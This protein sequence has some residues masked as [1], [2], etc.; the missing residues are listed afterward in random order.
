ML[1]PVKVYKLFYF[2]SDLVFT[3]VFPHLT[4]ALFCPEWVNPLGSAV[5]FIF[6]ALMRYVVVSSTA[7]GIKFSNLIFLFRLL[8]GEEI[9]NIPVYIRWPFFDEE[10]DMNLFPFK[11]FCML[12][13]LLGSVHT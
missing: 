11:S 6:G 7:N 10:N 8:S 2:C 13:T 5:A 3:L 4:T 9:L 1:N 12:L